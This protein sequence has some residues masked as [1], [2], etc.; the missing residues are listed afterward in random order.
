M[1]FHSKKFLEINIATVMLGFNG[2]FAKAIS[3]QPG[4]IIFLRSLIAFSVLFLFQKIS[5]DKTSVQRNHHHMII[6]LGGLLGIHWIT[7]FHSI[8]TSTI[9]IG[10]IST[11]TFPIVT[12]LL[13][14]LIHKE[15]WVRSDLMLAFLIMLGVICITPEIDFFSNTTQGVFWG[16]ISSL[17]YS[18]RNIFSKKYV[19]QYGGIYV[20][21]T[22]LIGV[23]VVSFPFISMWNFTASH[24]DILNIFLMGVFTT[25]IAH[26]LFVK[27]LKYISAK[28][29]SIITS[30]Q[31]VYSI[32]FASFIFLEVPSWRELLGGAIILIAV[33]LESAKH[34][35][36]EE[37]LID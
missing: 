13:E 10:V 30:F 34:S 29:A 25:A 2:I 26:T 18:F 16:L 37:V 35:K 27:S 32:V 28:T 36:K 1:N 11:F 4:V 12:A 3:L 31:V 8:Q 22:Q 23:L 17:A 33:L 7:L 21:R 6:F 19:K 20:M 5:E 14:P 9:A 24:V 15:S